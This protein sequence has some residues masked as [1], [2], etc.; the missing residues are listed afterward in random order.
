MN[1]FVTLHP[2]MRMS[3]AC[4]RYTLSIA[5]MTGAAV[6]VVLW[7]GTDRW[8]LAFAVTVV[9]A[10]LLVINVR[11]FGGAR[12]PFIRRLVFSFQRKSDHAHRGD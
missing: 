10:A 4:G 6:A 2:H 5:Q 12:D 9:A 11:A 3:S 1:L 8:T 7:V